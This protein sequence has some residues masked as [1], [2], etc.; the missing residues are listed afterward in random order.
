MVNSPTM[1]VDV[2][3]MWDFGNP[4][5]SEERFRAALIDANADDQLILWT[6]IARTFGLRKNFEEAREVLASV[7]PRLSEACPE[8]VVRYWLE[9][10]RTY[11]SPA[12]AEETQTD[13]AKEL[14]RQAYTAAFK[15][16]E[17]ARLDY[18][19][20]DALHMMTMV[21]TDPEGQIRW[22]QSALSYME[23]S[24][25]PEVK[26]WAGSLRNNLGYALHLAGRYG[27]AIAEY[28]KS[29]AAREAAGNISGARIARWMIARTL[30]EM[31]RLD[32]ALSIQLQLES[33]FD[34]AGEPDVYVFQE[35]EQIYRGMGQS[36]EADR[37]AAKAR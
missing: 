22:N 2:L 31:G 11:C 3:K 10:G 13:E 37:Y 7:E 29:K 28:E 5:L 19:A 30:R 32:D 25:Q 36:A 4:S 12:H 18:L 16:A 8:A 9:L 35:L 27:E 20:V 26:K 1:A 17:G 14:G 24:D 15:A 23:Q 21:D 33:E 34:E 6:Q